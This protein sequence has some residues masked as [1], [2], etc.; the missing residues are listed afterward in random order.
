MSPETE[1]ANWGS[2]VGG[3]KLTDIAAPSSSDRTAFPLETRHG[4]AIQLFFMHSIYFSIWHISYGY[5]LKV[6]DLPSPQPD[7]SVMH[8]TGQANLGT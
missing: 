1:G 8:F 3:G 7:H 2:V 4:A 6:E 5:F